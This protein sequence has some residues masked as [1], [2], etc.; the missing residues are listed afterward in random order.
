[1]DRSID[2]PSRFAKSRHRC[3]AMPKLRSIALG[4]AFPLGQRRRSLS[5]GMVRSRPNR[6]RAALMLI[7]DRENATAFCRLRLVGIL[8]AG[9]EHKNTLR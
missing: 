8:L 6:Q 7:R 1:M 4:L 9:I 5:A 2:E 3:P